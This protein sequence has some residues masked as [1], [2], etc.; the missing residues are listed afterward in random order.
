MIR[1]SIR[2]TGATN[3]QPGAACPRSPCCFRRAQPWHETGTD[4]ERASNGRNPAARR[5]CRCPNENRRWRPGDGGMS[6]VAR[7]LD[8]SIIHASQT[9]VRHTLLAPIAGLA[10]W[11]RRPEQRGKRPIGCLTGWLLA[12]HA[13][14]DAMVGCACASGQRTR[15]CRRPAHAPTAWQPAPMVR[16]DLEWASRSR[17]R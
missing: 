14:R 5:S 6:R 1:P 8:P 16:R 17:Q 7:V 2:S 15:A 3:Q 10:R 13:T 12:H 11:R 4:R 9:S